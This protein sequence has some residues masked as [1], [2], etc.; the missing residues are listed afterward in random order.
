MSKRKETQPYNFSYYTV[1]QQILIVK[2][3][4]FPLCILFVSIWILFLKAFS[5]IILSYWI[6][7]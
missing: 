3:K 1:I 2:H 5:L 6:L 7:V 4:H